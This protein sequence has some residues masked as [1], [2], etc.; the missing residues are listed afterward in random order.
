MHCMNR[1]Q[2]IRNALTRLRLYRLDA[3]EQAA[4]E[5]FRRD[6][7]PQWLEVALD[8]ARR[9]WSLIGSCQHKFL[10]PFGRSLPLMTDLDGS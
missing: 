5:R 4:M 8:C 3:T 9:R 6:R 10:D 1:R 7:D 2:F